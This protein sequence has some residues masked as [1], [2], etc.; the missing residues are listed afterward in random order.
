VTWALELLP[1]APQGTASPTRPSACWTWALAAARLRWRSRRSGHSCE[2]H[3]LDQSEAALA[4]ARANADRLGL[5]IDFRHGNWLDGVRERY[6][7]DRGQ[8]PYIADT[9]P[10]L[11]ALR[12]EPLRAL[13]AGANGLRDLAHHHRQRRPLPGAGR[14]AA[15][16][17]WVD[18]Q[19][20]SVCTLLEA[21]GFGQVRSRAD[22]AG[23]ARCSGGQRSG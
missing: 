7:A 19:A 23:I 9:D 13:S 6:H 22:L 20:G 2:V 8:P 4:V 14:L 17:A 11:A 15:A 1:P 21:A 16:G 3:A 12:H 5:T 18:D 10:H